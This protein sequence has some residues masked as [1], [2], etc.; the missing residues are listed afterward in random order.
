VHFALLLLRL[1]LM[2][3]MS[4]PIFSLFSLCLML[5]PL[6]STLQACR[7]FAPKVCV[8]YF[9]HF[10]AMSVSEI[11]YFTMFRVA[12]EVLHLPVSF[13]SLTFG[14]CY[15]L[16]TDLISS[17]VYYTV[18]ISYPSLLPLHLQR[19]LTICVITILFAL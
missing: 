14:V 13:T 2:L 18:Y 15:P 1:H 6:L 7:S 11:C 16:V 9:R 5:V 8:Q 17:M 12:L 19:V 3:F 4:C 10:S